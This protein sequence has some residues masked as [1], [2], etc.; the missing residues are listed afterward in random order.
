MDRSLIHRAQI[1]TK[2]ISRQVK[3]TS[4]NKRGGNNCQYN[5]SMQRAAMPMQGTGAGAETAE[6]LQH[7]GIEDAAD[8]ADASHLF[9]LNILMRASS[10]LTL[11][12]A[13]RAASSYGGSYPPS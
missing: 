13:P 10:K 9:K 5:R 12:K 3:H 8:L 6:D 2:V 7:N 1:T 11:A 4:Q